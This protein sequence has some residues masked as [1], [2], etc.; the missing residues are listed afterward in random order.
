MM[1]PGVYVVEHKTTALEIG[2]GS[3]Y[4]KRLTLDA[5]VSTYLAGAKAL[6]HDAVG[7]LYDVVRKPQI[8]PLKATPV[9]QREYTKPKDKACPECKKKNASPAPHTVDGLT[10]ADG[11]IVTDPGGRLYANMREFD[12]TPEEYAERLRADIAASPDKYYQRGTIVRLEDEARDADFD[13]WAVAKALRES[14]RLGRWPRNVDACDSYG[15][16]CEYFP[17][18]SGEATI[19]DPLRYRD[20]DEAHEE[21]ATI[22][23]DEKRRLPIVSSSSLKTYRSCPRKY[24]YAYEL[25]RRSLVESAA[26]RF[27][28]LLHLGLEVWWK[29]VDLAQAFA[30]MAGEADPFELV[31][32]QELMRGYHARWANEPFDVLAVEQGFVAPLV[33]PETNAESRTWQRGGKIDAI[34]RVGSVDRAA[35]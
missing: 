12:E 19:E 9:E 23:D 1:M 26:L 4:W 30:A 29:T 8:R 7:V 27:G 6:G 5:Q 2:A 17:V 14:Q 33:N 16:F 15:S 21:L 11:R 22:P 10:C 24:Y 34:V 28:T 20:A 18:C 35:A 25:R 13:A 32:A 3:P 31:K